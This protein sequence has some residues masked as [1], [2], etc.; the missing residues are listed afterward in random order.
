MP[1]KDPEAE[2]A[3]QANYRKT[4]RPQ[5]HIAQHRYD[6]KNKA[7]KNARRRE[8][9]AENPQKEL[10]QCAEYRKAHPKERCALV[11]AYQK[12]N[13]EKVN[14]RNSR[15]HAKRRGALVNDLTAAQWQAIQEAQDHRCAYCGKRAKGRLHREHITP[16][17]EGGGTTLHNI[18]AACVHCN[19]KKGTGPVLCPVQPLLLC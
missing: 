2:R 1:Y 18:V 7:K 11:R 13:P 15:N 3:Y 16:A 6:V 19:S 8:R 4:H 10:E 14:T 12:R 5:I 9:Y 17:S